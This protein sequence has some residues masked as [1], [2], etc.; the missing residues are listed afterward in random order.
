M[1]LACT[2]A[3]TLIRAWPVIPQAHLN[4]LGARARLGP[5]GIWVFALASRHS[6]RPRP[7][8]DQL[9]VATAETEGTEEMKGT[10]WIVKTFSSYKLSAKWLAVIPTLLYPNKSTQPR[11]ENEGS[12][13]YLL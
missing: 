10:K 6:P 12:M 8:L 11:R 1:L 13:A 7:V 4:C 2:A 9:L 3:F 5:S